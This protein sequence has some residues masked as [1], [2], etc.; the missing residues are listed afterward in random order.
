M[1]FVTRH[2]G[3]TSGGRIWFAA[4]AAAPLAMVLA[5][6]SPEG[7]GTVK[8][9]GPQ[10]ARSKLEGA[11]GEGPKTP[12]SAKQAKALETEKAAAKKNPKLF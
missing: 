5:G 11:S 4:L 9:G 3:K 7:T 1:V 10:E 2:I 6:C 8:V 12:T